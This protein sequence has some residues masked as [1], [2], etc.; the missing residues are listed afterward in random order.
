MLESPFTR[1]LSMTD[2]ASKMDWILIVRS[3]LNS[4]IIYFPE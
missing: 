1:M 2:D 4:V 3:D